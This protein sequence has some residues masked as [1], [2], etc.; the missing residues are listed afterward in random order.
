MD[1]AVGVPTVDDVGIERVGGQVAALTRAHGRPVA[2]GDLPVVTPARDRGGARVLLR[3]VHTVREGVVGDHVVKLGRGL[4]V[5]AA[6]RTAAVERDHGALVAPDDH[7]RRVPRIDPELVVV[8]TAGLALED[9]EGLTAVG[10]LEERHVRHVYDIGV[11]GIDGDA[12]KV[13]V[14]AG[15]TRIAPAS[16]QVAPASSERY[17]P[18]SVLAPIKA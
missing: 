5:P 1:A 10:R 18:P 15:E 6:P 12:T 16:C 4:V 14:A 9:G 11:L 7:V 2:E 17:S 13:P 8:V 3:A